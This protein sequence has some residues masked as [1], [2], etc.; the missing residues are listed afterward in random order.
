MAAAPRSC[1]EPPQSHAASWRATSTPNRSQR[2]S[3]RDTS[4][5]PTCLTWTCCGALAPSS[6]RPTSSPGT[7][8][9]PNCSSP[10]ASGQTSTAATYGTPSPSTHDAGAA[11]AR[12]PADL[13]ANFGGYDPLA[14]SDLWHSPGLLRG[15]ARWP[16]RGRPVPLRVGGLPDFD[17]MTVGIAD[18]AALLVLV[19]FRRRQELGTAGAPFGVYGLDVFDP[20]IEE[21]ADPVGIGWRLQGDRRLVVGRA[22]A[23]IDDDPAVG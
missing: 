7:P 3:S 1:K 14:A 6:A 5:C 21:A 13:S 19:L 22:S 17:Q 9:T 8:R 10:P 11:T 15:H 20:D 23:D 12:P 18:V 2:A 4:R 16:V